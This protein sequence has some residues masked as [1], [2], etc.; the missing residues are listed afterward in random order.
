MAPYEALYRRKCQ[1]PLCW[2]EASEKSLLGL[3]MIAETTEQI[4]K[5]RSQMLVAQSRQK[6]YADQRRKPLEFKEI[7]HVFLNITP[8]TGMGR[9]IKTK[10]LNPHYIGPFEIWK[11]IGSVAYRIALLP[12][13]SN[14]H[15]V[16]NV[17]QLQKYTP[18]ASHVLELEL[19]QVR[20]DMTFPIVSVRI[21]DP[22]IKR[23]LG[24]EVSLAKVVW[25]RASIEKHTWEL[26]LAMRNDYPHIFLGN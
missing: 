25:I 7:E 19:V 22:N 5:I 6:S 13:L 15:N 4:K 11:R 24:N 26:E 23:L 14:L 1:S 9:A 21:D 8:T 16:F 17:L 10:K 12:H 3:E 18:D 20:E 2:Y